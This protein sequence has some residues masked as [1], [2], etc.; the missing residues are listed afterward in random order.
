MLHFLLLQSANADSCTCLEGC[1]WGVGVF[2]DRSLMILRIC[3]VRPKKDGRSKLTRSDV[4]ET[5][6]PTA[7]QQNSFKARGAYLLSQSK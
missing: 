3:C 5:E 4:D 2:I 6:P 7:S 1:R